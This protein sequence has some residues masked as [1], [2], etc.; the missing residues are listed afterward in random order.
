MIISIGAL[1]ISVSYI[2]TGTAFGF[3]KSLLNKKRLN[4]KHT[5]KSIDKSIN[6]SNLEDQVEINEEL[7]K[8]E[9][10]FVDFDEDD[11]KEETII[12]K[13]IKE[14]KKEDLPFEDPFE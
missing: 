7:A 14:D 8:E 10:P 9:K 5:E 11:S 13:E 2:L 3:Y 12:E 6:I 4:T 1:A